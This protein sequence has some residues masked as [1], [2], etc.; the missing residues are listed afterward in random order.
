MIIAIIPAK[1]SS[2]RL[3]NKNMHL[4]LGKPMLQYAI[5]Y[6]QSSEKVSKIYISTDNKIIADYAKSKNIE[7]IMRSNKLGGEVPLIEVYKDAL[8]KIK[9][10]N[11]DTLAGVQPDHPDRNISLDAILQIFENQNLDLLSSTELD[12]TKNGAYHIM[13]VKSMIAGEFLNKSVIQD[14]CTNVHY[15]SDILLAEERLKRLKQ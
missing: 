13:S 1:G 6:A 10:K 2:S 9:N 8:Y 5:D 14:D 12:G 15:K 3:P 4:V 11:I 7:V